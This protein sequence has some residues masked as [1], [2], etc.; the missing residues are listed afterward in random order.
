MRVD[1]TTRI[2]W[3]PDE[4]GTILR[5]QLDARLDLDLKGLPGL[6]GEPLPAAMAAA[7]VP[8][9]SY[10]EIL[11]QAATPI[12][13]LRTAKEFFKLCRNHPRSPLPPE[14]A[15]VLYF[16]C[17]AVAQV[18]H[19]QRITQM[20]EESLRKGIAWALQRPWVDEQ[21]RGVLIDVTSQW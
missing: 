10:R 9:H 15:M 17:I 7:Q 2:A 6:L 11:G 5:H 1:E 12:E 21:T 13:V 3:R 4:L 20:D 18:R 16:A 14:V 19:G 8:P